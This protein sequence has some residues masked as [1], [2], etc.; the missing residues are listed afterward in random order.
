VLLVGQYEALDVHATSQVE[1]AHHVDG[2]AE[3]YLPII[4]RVD[5]QHRRGPL[6]GGCDG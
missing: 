1:R 2:L 6:P 5:E 4:V 3:G